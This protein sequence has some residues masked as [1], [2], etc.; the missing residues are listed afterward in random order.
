LNP[1]KSIS[2]LRQRQ[3]ALKSGLGVLSKKINNRKIMLDGQW[4]VGGCEYCQNIENAGGFS[5]RMYHL[6]IPNLNP[7]ELYQDPA[8]V[9]VTPQIV[10][11]YLNNTCNLA[12]TYCDPAFSSRIEHEIKR[13]GPFDN[14][15]IKIVD[16]N[17]Y[18]DQDLAFK[19]FCTWLVENIHSIKRLHFAGG[20]TFFQRE[21]NV[22]LD[23]IDQNPN[24]HLEINFIS[25]LMAAK[26][27]EYVDRIKKM[28]LDK[29]IG[30]LDIT[31]SLDCWGPEAEYIRHG[32]E[33]DKWEENFSYLVNQ[34]WIK[35]T[36]N[37]VITAM[38]VRTTADLIERLNHYRKIRDINHNF[39]LVGSNP[40]LHPRIFGGDMWAKD[41]D[42]MLEIF[43][44]GYG[45]HDNEREYLAGI[46]Q[47][48]QS[49]EV[50]STMIERMHVYLN[51]LDRR[52]NTNWKSLF[53][54]LDI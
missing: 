45:A 20:E 51:E 6:E 31:A 39:L 46:F 41:F 27:Q 34:K 22:V 13:F 23:I 15:G 5:D 3:H 18:V 36:V 47:Y 17:T 53:P 48:L 8:A 33:L 40:H 1:I 26:T 12:C 37:S 14:G 42:R 2:P 19:N 54:Y 7:P 4:P 9:S 35:I 25:N 30:R 21:L 50:D 43:P 29:K 38:S 16:A 24:K 10:E 11:I 44:S 32:L 28:I 52:R 49:C